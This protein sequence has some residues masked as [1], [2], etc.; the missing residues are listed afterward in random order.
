MPR[1]DAAGAQV[2]LDALMDKMEVQAS[3]LVD[4]AESAHELRCDIK[5]V[6][7]AACGNQNYHSCGTKLPNPICGASESPMCGLLCGTIR[8]FTVSTVHVTGVTT[9]DQPN[10]SPL[11]KESICWTRLLDETFL[12]NNAANEADDV[13]FPSDSDLPT[14]YFGDEATGLFRDF[15]GGYDS[16]TWSAGC[17][18]YDPR[19]RPWYTTAMSPPKDVIILLDASG[20]MS[21]GG[22][23]SKLA[24]AIRAAKYMIGRFSASDSF[25]IVTFGTRTQQIYPEGG[26]MARG[27]TSDKANAAGAI[28]ADDATNGVG[29]SWDGGAAFNLAYDLLNSGSGTT[30]CKKSIVLL[31]DN[32]NSASELSGVLAAIETRDDINNKAAIFTYSIGESAD[33]DGGLGK[34]IACARGGIWAA[35]AGEDFSTDMSAFCTFQ[36]FATVILSQPFVFGTCL[37]DGCGW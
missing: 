34:S 10:L 5:T 20:S 19:V 15:P 24:Q 1:L 2:E 26:G 7:E 30:G 11:W 36:I 6:G 35:V 25:A 28:S 3:A 18:S 8:D 9:R 33:L 13:S 37:R 12:A 22:A 4:R 14:S 27:R 16:S 31:T 29:P 21:V 23:S 32:S 17:G